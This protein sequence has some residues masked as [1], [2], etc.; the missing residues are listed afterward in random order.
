MK[1]VENPAPFVEGFWAEFY[2]RGR[3]LKYSMSAIA[4]YLMN[5]SEE[6]VRAT[7]CFANFSKFQ[8]KRR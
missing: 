1:N 6:N 2:T 5:L 8:H 7:N 4:P 3:F